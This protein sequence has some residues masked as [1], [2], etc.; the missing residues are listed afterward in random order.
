MSLEIL[1]ATM[2]KVTTLLHHFLLG[3]GITIFFFGG[4]TARNVFHLDTEM[5]FLTKHISQNAAPQLRRSGIKAMLQRWRAA[6]RSRAVLQLLLE[7]QT[8]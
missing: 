3:A 4:V 2:L 7:Q 8:T 1:D 6:P 5:G